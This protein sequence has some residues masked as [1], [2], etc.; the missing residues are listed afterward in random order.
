M[1]MTPEQ[2]ESGLSLL[3]KPVRIKVIEEWMQCPLL[4][5]MRTALRKRYL[6]ET[7]KDNHYER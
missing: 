1:Q 6:N 7:D 3:S 4:P 5:E 2:A